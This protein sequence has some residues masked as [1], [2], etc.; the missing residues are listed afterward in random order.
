MKTTWSEPKEPC[1]TECCCAPL[2]HARR[3]ARVAVALG[4]QAG[5][6]FQRRG[7]QRVVGLPHLAQIGDE[8]RSI[9]GQVRDEGSMLAA[10]PVI[11][12]ARRR[13]EQLSDGR[14]REVVEQRSV[15]EQVLA[16]ATET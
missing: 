1:E 9:Q 6:R 12:L 3:P 7:G 11:G 15:V 8:R 5:G 4:R 16:A 14:E 2:R 10:L 13:A